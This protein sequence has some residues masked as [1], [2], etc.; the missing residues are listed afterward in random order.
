MPD[1]K[2]G[3]LK[4]ISQGKDS[5]DKARFHAL[6]LSDI[7]LGC[8]D[9]KADFL[10]ALLDKV[11]CDKLYLVGDIIDFWA[12]KQRIF[13]PENHNLL[14]RRLIALAGA[15]TE[16]IYIPGNH[17]E[18]LKPYTGLT[19][20][21]VALQGHYVHQ[22]PTG[23]RLLLVHGDQFDAE[24]CIGRFYARLGDHL[25]D[26]LLFLNR[27]LHHWR[28]RLGYPYWSLAGYLKRRVGKAQQ[29]ISRYR[30]AAVRHGR[31]QA[32]DGVIC[33]HIHQ[34]SL[35]S[36]GG[37]IYANDGDWIE[38]CTLV[39]ETHQ[40]TLQLLRWDEGLQGP[41]VEQEICLHTAELLGANSHQT[42][43]FKTR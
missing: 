34:P 38:N 4:S 30:D 14:L 18:L 11:H 41:R 6:W 22:S 2:T 43:L 1:A 5:A 24:V 33:G 13:W 15:G 35:S 9:C 16:V 31:T 42:G 7:H 10:Q 21:Q 25:Y 26:L 37:F 29:A 20:W 28:A 12:L 27:Q 36:H 8:K 40:G 3:P 17:D 23:K 19:V 32:M 39:A